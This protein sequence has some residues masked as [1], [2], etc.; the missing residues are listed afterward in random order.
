[1][2]LPL[3]CKDGLFAP[4]LKAVLV[5]VGFTLT[6]YDG[7]RIADVAAQVGVWTSAAAIEAAEPAIRAEMAQH[8]WPQRRGS[9]ASASGGP[10]FFRRLLE[11]AGGR[12]EDDPRT[13]DEAAARLW[14]CHLE[15]NLWSRVLDGVPEALASLRAAGLG[16]AVVSNSEGTLEALLHELDL[17]RHFDLVLDSWVVGVTKPDARIFELALEGVGADASEAVMVGDSPAADIAGA[18]AAGLRAALLDPFDLHPELGPLP[19]DPAK[20]KGRAV[21]VTRFASFPAFA[22]ALLRTRAPAR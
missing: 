22:H 16:L 10:R 8:A 17:A 11:L 4:P 6:S 12:G 7:R 15:S 3:P 1:M 14:Q 18:A 2:V 9:E 19:V 20:G 21:A 5:D 13:L